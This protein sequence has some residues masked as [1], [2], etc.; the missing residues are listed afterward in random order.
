MPPR[1]RKK[2]QTDEVS[3]KAL[4][5]A[6]APPKERPR[7]R[8]VR[9]ADGSERPVRCERRSTSERN[10]AMADWVG[11]APGLAS[12]AH[13]RSMDSLLAEVLG[14]MEFK[15]ETLAPELLA[16]AWERAAGSFLATQASLMSV[17]GGKAIIRT[18]HPL[19]R[20]ELNQRKLQIIRILNA[21]LGEGSVTTVRIAHG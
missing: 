21:E 1:R 16:A 15:E 13:M 9:Y 8:M 18:N 14:G 5:T 7:F 11:A 19:V 6:P 12:S 10:Q 2:P 3:A 4:R 17:S 20:M